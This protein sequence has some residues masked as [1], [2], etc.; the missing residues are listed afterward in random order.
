MPASDKRNRKPQ[1]LNFNLK[2]VD[3]RYVIPLIRIE[4]GNSVNIQ[5]AYTR[6]LGFLYIRAPD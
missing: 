2:D 5:S 3:V 4:L 1:V 6:P